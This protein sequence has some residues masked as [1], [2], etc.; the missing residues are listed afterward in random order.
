MSSVLR[1]S[2]PV[3]SHKAS[4]VSTL[5]PQIKTANFKHKFCFL[6]LKLSKAEECDF[7]TYFSLFD[8]ILSLLNVL[9]C[10]MRIIIL[11]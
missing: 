8:Y 9:F 6:F 11:K 4:T 2:R 7:I 1:C 3:P 10:K 5:Y